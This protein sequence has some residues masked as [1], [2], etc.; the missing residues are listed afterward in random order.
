MARL[1]EVDVPVFAV[2]VAE[3]LALEMESHGGLGTNSL[4]HIVAQQQ[5]MAMAD[6]TGGRAWFPRFDAEVIDIMKEVAANL[7]FEYSM[8][9][10]PTNQ[11][12]DGKYRKIKIELVD[13]GG[14]PLVV[15]DARGKKI[16]FLVHTRQGY[17]APKNSIVN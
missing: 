16:K 11:K 8:T 1:K 13:D 15:N 17:T 9:Y 10:T 3:Q 14:K 7:R 4:N 2:G 12:T 5:M 6:T